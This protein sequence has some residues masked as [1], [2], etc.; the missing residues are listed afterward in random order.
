MTGTDFTNADEDDYLAKVNRLRNCFIVRPEHYVSFNEFAEILAK[1]GILRIVFLEE[2]ESLAIKF[3]S[4]FEDAK[5][6]EC[7]IVPKTKRN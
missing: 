7:Q 4:C 5:Q 1:V 3:S 6:Y 2:K